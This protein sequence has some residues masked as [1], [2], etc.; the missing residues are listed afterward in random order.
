M[1][2]EY[3]GAKII[4]LLRGRDMSYMINYFRRKGLHIGDMCN[5]YSNIVTS[6]S[7]LIT[8]KNNVTISNDV[9]IITHDNS[10]CKVFKEYTD[11]FGEVEIG[12][13]C[14]IGAKTIILPGV[15]LADNIIVGSGSVVTK[16]FYEGNIVIAGN[17]AKKI[18]TIEQYKNKIRNFG[19]DIRGLSHK[20]KESLLT[21][22]RKRLV[23][24]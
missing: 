5:I 9:Q 17:P 4:Y 13:N 24:K 7:F 22:N 21:E 3:L 6:E 10:I 1:S 15:V 23:K 12:H 14:F 11:V 18:C 16:S 2:I 8:I 20:E 19:F